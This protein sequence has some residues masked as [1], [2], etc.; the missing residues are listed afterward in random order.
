M[1]R[2][3]D[4]LLRDTLRARAA[5]PAA[6]CLDPETAAAFVDGTM[7]ARARA[8][9]EAHLAD[10]PRCQAV[11]AA[12]VRSTPPPIERVWWRRP[13]VAWLAP[14][15]IAATAVAIWINVPDSTRRTP[16]QTQ[17]NEAP[18]LASSPV[19]LPTGTP[20]A[21]QTQSQFDPAAARLA[22]AVR[23]REAADDS[24]KA[25]LA[26][27]T[28]DA[29]TDNS[30]ARKVLVPAQGQSQAAA[31][32]RSSARAGTDTFMADAVARVAKAV[33]ISSDG[34]SQWRAGSNGQVLHSADGGR[35][36]QTQGTGVNVMPAA[37]SAPSASVCWLVGPGG[38]VLI[39]TDEGQ[40][41]RRL[42]FPVVTDLV[43]VRATDDRTATIVSSDGRTFATSDGG[44]TWKQ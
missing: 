4:D 22:E 28:A 9:A 30:D 32:T 8:S 19:Q 39:T 35:T 2:S 23:A 42:P 15:T 43:S 14:L 27:A 44:R 11:L 20:A 18:P 31:P 41:W 21:P 16:V 3:M 13:A 17:R 10:C 38:L 34:A 12:L 40:S 26:R 7:S 36:W 6:A 25:R 24:A 29:L 5:D 1:K 37:G 33:V